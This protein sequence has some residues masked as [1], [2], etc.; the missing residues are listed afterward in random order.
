MARMA[1]QRLSPG[2]SRRDKARTHTSTLPKEP[3]QRASAKR[4]AQTAAAARRSAASHQE[5]APWRKTLTRPE[6]AVRHPLPS[7]LS[8]PHSGADNPAA[9]TSSPATTAA[10]PSDAP[11]PAPSSCSRRKLPNGRNRGDS[12]THS[13][14]E[15]LRLCRYNSRYAAPPPTVSSCPL[16]LLSSPLQTLPNLPN[17]S[18]KADRPQVHRWQGP[19]QAPRHQ[20]RP[21]ERPHHR[22]SAAKR[23][24]RERE[25]RGKERKS[26]R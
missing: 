21:Q 17:G 12:A 9:P 13:Y 18:H 19:A 11:L 2:R 16:Q 10:R 20:G 22:T 23:Q 3:R 14:R 24:R 7:L 6:R 25:E 26:G 8:I 4:A 15:K 5:S 1:Q